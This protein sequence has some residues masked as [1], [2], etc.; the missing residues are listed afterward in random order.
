MTTETSNAG[1]LPLNRE[2]LDQL[3]KEN[4]AAP[5]LNPIFEAVRDYGVKLA[6]LMRGAEPVDVLAP[7]NGHPFIIMV[8]D[9]T[10]ICPGPTGFELTSL[11]TALASVACVAVVS[12]QPP[13][14]LYRYISLLPAFQCANAAIIETRPEHDRAWI[15]WLYDNAPHARLILGTPFPDQFAKQAPHAG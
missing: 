9:D 4:T 7:I 14:A 15:D 13:E 1:V 2:K 11:K 10:D 6:V 3:L 5:H 8:A 12:C